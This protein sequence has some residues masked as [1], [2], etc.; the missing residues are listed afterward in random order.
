MIFKII[1]TLKVAFNCFWE[2]HFKTH[3]ILL[4][5]EPTNFCNVNCVACPNDQLKRKKGYMDLDLFKKIVDETA[6]YTLEYALDMMGEPTLHKD[7]IAMI[8]H[9]KLK[10]G[11]VALYTNLNFEDLDL[12][13]QLVDIKTDR[14][15]V[16]I[17][18][19]DTIPYQKTIRNGNFDIVLNNLHKIKKIIFC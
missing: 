4:E 19:T 6:P 18:E 14:L 9:V 8:K 13:E 5:I 2:T 12:S 15:I 7:L 1:N 17:L 3:L 16:N 11:K 10:G